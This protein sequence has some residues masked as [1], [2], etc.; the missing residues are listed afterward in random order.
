MIEDPQIEEE[1]EEEESQPTLLFR[2][3]HNQLITLILVLLVIVVFLG[4]TTRTFLTANNI[5]NVLRAFSWI[6]IAA[7]GQ[8]M[9]IIGGGIDLSCGSNMAFCGIVAGAFLVAGYPVALAVLVALAVGAGIGF[10]NGFMVSRTYLPP[11]IATLGMMSIIRGFCYGLTSG[12]PVR[13]LPQSFLFLGQADIPFLAWKIPLPAI[14]MVAFAIFSFI[15]LEKTKLG[16]HIYAV[17]GNEYAA[18]LAGINCSRVKLVIFTLSGLFAGLGG[19]LM[20]SRLGVAAPTAASGYELDVI[21]A[22]AIGG[23]SLDGGEGSVW[24]ALIG[25]ALMQILRNALVLLGFPAYW[26]PSAIGAVIIGAVMIDQYRK[27]RI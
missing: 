14:I 6:A 3:F 23:I 15:L 22:A 7:F 5:F 1:R 25:A 8:S 17:G 11:F 20:T 9:V 18:S 4:V 10:L 16:Y 21:A 13:G 27:R 26:Q 2:I 24:G 19:I 12:W